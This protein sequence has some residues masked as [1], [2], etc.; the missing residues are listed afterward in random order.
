MRNETTRTMSSDIIDTNENASD[1]L[2]RDSLLASVGT[3]VRDLRKEKSWS[4]EKL[5]QEARIN[6][7]YVYD[8][9]I[10]SRCIWI[11]IL[12]EATDARLT[13]VTSDFHFGAAAGNA[14][15]VITR[16]LRAVESD[17]EA[18]FAADGTKAASAKR[19]FR[20]EDPAAGGITSPSPPD[21][22]KAKTRKWGSSRRKADEDGDAPSVS[23][24][25][26][27]AIVFTGRRGSG[28]TSTAVN[29][30][31]TASRRGVNTL[32]VDLDV[33]Y[34]S[35]NLYFGEYYKQAENDEAVASSLIRTLA[36]PQSYQT[37]AVNIGSNLWLT[38]L[39]Y[40][41]FDRKL[42]EQHFTEPKVIGL[43]TALKNSFDFIAIDIPLDSFA[44]FPS[45][46]SNIDVISL[47]MD[48]TIYSAITTLR[49]ISLG[50]AERERI[51]YLASKCKLVVTKHDDESMYND[52]IITPDRLSELIASE[53]FSEDFE[54]EL[55]VAGNVPYA[56]WF[57]KQI[58]TD[59][60]V[61]D[62]DNRMQ[63]AFDE[64]LLRLLGAA[65]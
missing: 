57:G 29:T 64:I 61:I 38:S 22:S 8:I 24:A 12:L 10:G 19:L 27:K 2:I 6:D 54:F 45:L 49:N 20:K 30:A 23:L 47:C 1:F 58:E 14:K 34:R 48:N 59:I 15:I 26:S 51:A 46:L 52:E 25:S 21:Q 31:V 43:V 40:G 39:G 53:G 56:S 37:T 55:P 36:Q 17:F 42:I 5:A 16:W 35:A 65:R 18:V 3:H 44:R 63:R 32:L 9:E 50:F 11:E 33:D 13:V 62:M 28:V 60:P 7:K 4:Q 41:F